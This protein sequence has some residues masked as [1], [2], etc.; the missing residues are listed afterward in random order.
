M[1][2]LQ[3]AIALHQ[4]G[5][6]LAAEA[7][8]RRVLQTEPNNPDA[9]ALLG[10]VLSELKQ[11]DEAIASLNKALA[12]DAQAPLFHFQLGNALDKA[13]KHPE[14]ENAFAMATAIAPQWGEAWYNLGNAQRAQNKQSAKDSY[15]RVLK[16]DPRHALAH[17]NLAMML[18]K[19]G[20]LPGAK[21]LIQ[22][23][24]K[25][26]PDNSSLLLNLSDVA[27]EQNDLPTALGAV[28]K[29]ASM[30]LGIPANDTSYLSWPG[31]F[32]NRDEEGRNTL[33]TLANGALLQGHLEEAS[34]ILRGLMA[35]DPDMEEAFT[36]YGAVAQARNAMGFA[37]ECHAQSFMLDPSNTTAPWNRSM[38][39][40]CDGDLFEGFRRY[41]WRWHVLDK[42]KHIRLDK[43]MWNG[44]DLNGK[45]LLIQE[46]Q[47]FGDT[48]QMLRFLPALKARG[49]K[50]YIYAQPALYPLLENWNAFD[51]IISWDVKIKTAPAEVDYVIGVMDI[52]G[53][54]GIGLNN[55]PAKVPYL[56]NPHANDA[57]YKLEG[58]KPKIALVWAGNPKHKRDHE[59]SVPFE[60][61]KTLL[62]SDADFYSLQHKPKEDDQKQLATLGII[63]LAPRVKNLADMAAFLAQ[64]DLL[65][66]ID[67]AP[68]HL[69]GGLGVPTWLL[70]TNH[71]DWRWLLERSDTPWYPS[72]NI[73]RQP[74]AGDW[75]GALSQLKTALQKGVSKKAQ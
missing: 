28:R 46:E 24:L 47:G 69:A 58:T 40:L 53:A 29:A 35:E 17:N 36:S 33:L 42:H 23:G 43:P 37:S 4:R 75:D 26:H 74:V 60:K 12:L 1:A 64:M 27:F 39:Q 52:P 72:V 68:A 62:N 8:Y 18:F 57:T 34:A 63:D 38:A 19:A 31:F 73:Y 13:G 5:E 45:T 21:A 71:P 15:E 16:L 61:F 2:P 67:S 14:A 6:W 7:A 51:K 56:P 9:L 66:T 54:L 22:E 41:R 3:Q 50:L 65:I 30:K 32:K 49:A 48:L 55:I 25:F 20:D 11:H 70:V 10:A 44:E 59:R